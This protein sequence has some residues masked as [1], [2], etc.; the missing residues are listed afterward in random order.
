VTGL[1]EEECEGAIR[2]TLL[3]GFSL[4]DE[5]ARPVF[6][7]RLHQFVSKGETV[8]ASPEPEEDRHITLE[9]QQ[10]VPNS[11]RKKVLLPLAFCRECGQEYYLVR[12]VLDRDGVTR[13]V[14]RELSDR[15]DSDDGEAG[16]LYI[17]VSDIWP[18]DAEKER[19]R[20]PDAWIEVRKGKERIRDARR[21]R[22]PREVFISADGGHGQGGIRAYWLGTPYVLCMHCGVSYEPTQRSD[23]GKLATLGTE[24]GAAPRRS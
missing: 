6:A 15:T 14:P 18:T 11:D 16:F 5:F 20:L 8:Y 9:R 13:Y 23:F 12:K 2:N 10:F 19:K 3:T 22:L 24:G 7:F 17:S 1:S 21:N 4:V